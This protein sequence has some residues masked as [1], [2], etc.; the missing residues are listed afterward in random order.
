[1]KK[2]TVW[3]SLFALLLFTGNSPAADAPYP[4]AAVKVSKQKPAAKKPESLGEA[5]IIQNN[6]FVR[7][8]RPASISLFNA[9]GELLFHMDSMRSF[10]TLPLAGIN[11]GFLYLILRAG[12][13][14]MTTKLVYT[15]K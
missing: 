9:R 10:E 13:V 7:L 12:S 4:P 5:S 2:K 1:M 11:A 14:E 6:L 3:L 8:V 15:G